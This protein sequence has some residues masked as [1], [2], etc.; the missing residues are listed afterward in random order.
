[1]AR[2]EQSFRVMNKKRAAIAALLIAAP[3]PSESN[4]ALPTALLRWVLNVGCLLAFWARH[5]LKGYFLAF[6]Q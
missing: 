4:R 2:A 6:F 1:M 3:S 5:Y